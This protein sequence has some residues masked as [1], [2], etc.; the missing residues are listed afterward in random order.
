VDSLPLLTDLALDNVATVPAGTAFLRCVV[1]LA[2]HVDDV[3]SMVTIVDAVAGKPGLRGHPGI[4]SL[5]ANATT[6]LAT[7]EV[8]SHV[9][10]AHWQSVCILMGTLP[11]LVHLRFSV[12]LPIVLLCS[13]LCWLSSGCLLCAGAHRDQ[14]GA[15]RWFAL[16]SIASRCWQA[17]GDLRQP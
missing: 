3:Q 17:S 11:Q 5:R 12:L 16:S 9:P 2:T 1:N 15:Q 7:R 10:R 8:R 6:V 13:C 14:H 4:A